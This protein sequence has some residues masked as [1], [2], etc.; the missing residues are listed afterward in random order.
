MI[1]HRLDNMSGDQECLPPIPDASLTDTY[2]RLTDLAG[3]RVGGVPGNKEPHI[4]LESASSRYRATAGCNGLGGQYELDGGKLTLKPGIS[5]MMA[6]QPPVDEYERGLKEALNNT[7]TWE[8]AG[9]VLSLLDT[10]GNAVAR[11]RAVYLQ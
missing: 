10:E 1:V 7:V 2:W 5:T 3:E 6:C 8:I 11:F 4:L 9:V